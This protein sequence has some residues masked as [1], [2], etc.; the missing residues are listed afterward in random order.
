MA[1]Q[2]NNI[3]FK[4]AQFTFNEDGQILIHEFGKDS[5]ETHNLTESLKDFSGDERFV[6]LV[7]REKFDVEGIDGE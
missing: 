7:I 6:D 3:T 1:V 2:N 4:N 5:I